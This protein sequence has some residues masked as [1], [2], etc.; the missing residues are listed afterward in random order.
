[1]KASYLFK[2]LISCLLL[3]VISTAALFAGIS[4][5]K[6]LVFFF[7]IAGALS[8]FVG[9]LLLATGHLENDVTQRK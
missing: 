5:M 1:M 8:L 7:V 3:A 6:P 2:W 4:G 9:L